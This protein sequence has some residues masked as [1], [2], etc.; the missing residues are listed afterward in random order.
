MCLIMPRSYTTHMSLNFISHLFSLHPPF[1]SVDRNSICC[2]AT[3]ISPPTT[4]FSSPLMDVYFNIYTDTIYYIFERKYGYLS[5]CVS[6]TLLN[7]IISVTPISL[8]MLGFSGS[9]WDWIKLEGQMCKFHLSRLV[10]F[11]AYWK[12]GNI[13][14]DTQ[15]TLW[16][17][18]VSSSDVDPGAIVS[19]LH[20]QS[21]KFI[22]T[23]I[24]A[25]PAYKPTDQ[26][27]NLLLLFLLHILS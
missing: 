2:H 25:I 14:K 10:P 15:E 8:Q 24:V 9:S 16:C 1:L 20:F 12:Q 3:S 19:E 11:S 17:V 13:N 21:G 4:I 18:H 27:Q 22:L 23:S 7:T 26:T 6:L 5:F